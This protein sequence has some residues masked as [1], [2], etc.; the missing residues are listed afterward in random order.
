MPKIFR[1]LSTFQQETSSG[2]QGKKIKRPHFGVK[3]EKVGVLNLVSKSL[4]FVRLEHNLISK[5]NGHTLGHLEHLD[6]L[7]LRH[8]KIQS[9]SKESLGKIFFLRLKKFTLFLCENT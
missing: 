5:V 1:E 3:N 4:Q 9:L 2:S 6:L 8:N 7:D